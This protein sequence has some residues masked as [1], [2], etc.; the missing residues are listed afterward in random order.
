MKSDAS[1]IKQKYI[2]KN[3]IIKL[4]RMFEAT[5]TKFL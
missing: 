5:S 1:A 4:F 3:K 2:G